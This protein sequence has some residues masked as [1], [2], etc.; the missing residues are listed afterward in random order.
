MFNVK[1]LFEF[2]TILIVIGMILLLAA[3]VVGIFAYRKPKKDKDDTDIE[4]KLEKITLEE[5]LEKIKEI[6]EEK[7][8]ETLEEVK[9][10]PIVVEEAKEEIPV[11]PVV[12]TPVVEEK[13]VEEVSK[14]EVEVLE[15]SEEIKEESPQVEK[16]GD[17]FIEL[18][19]LEN[20]KKED[21][22]TL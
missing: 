13:P 12:E 21:V 22:E 20:Q 10:E 19:T 2:P 5:N 7:K 16:N 15:V 4:E 14:S 17:E 18:I 9:E 11:E 3:V 1:A 8:V 6:T